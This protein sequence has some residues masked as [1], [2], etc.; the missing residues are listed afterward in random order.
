ME[1]GYE[2]LFIN[3]LFTSPDDWPFHTQLMLDAALEP[4][5][6]KKLERFLDHV[7]L[8]PAITEDRDEVMSRVLLVLFAGLSPRKSGNIPDPSKECLVAGVFFEQLLEKNIP[9]SM[10]HANVRV[11]IEIM[12]LLGT[13][14]KDNL[15]CAPVMGGGAV[16]F[17]TNTRAMP[18]LEVMGITQMLDAVERA[19]I[20]AGAGF[21]LEGSSGLDP[22]SDKPTSS[23]SGFKFD[24]KAF[25]D[26]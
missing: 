4:Q 9:I 19:I 11:L 16:G 24:F 21:R 25:S 2:T 6:H 23:Y 20:D 13:A 18:L 5:A 15:V 14:L 17:G 22:E 1:K 3:L 10:S 7:K 8:L 12:Q 26:N